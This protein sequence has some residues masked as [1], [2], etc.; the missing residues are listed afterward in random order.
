MAAT[1]EAGRDSERAGP[2]SAYMRGRFPFLGI[3]GPRLARSVA[4]LLRELK[5]A[6]EAD[7]DRL[8]RHLWQRPEREFQYVGTMLVRRYVGRCSPRFLNT[9]E[10]LI[11]TKSWWDTVD[12]L[13]KDGVG[14]LV[15]AHP[16]LAAAMDRWAASENLW[17][18]RSAILHQLRFK[19]ATDPDRLFAYCRRRAADRDFFLRKAIGWALRE[20]SKTDPRAVRVFVEQHAGELSG[21]SKREALRWL[22]RQTA[23]AR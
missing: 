4:P 5:A 13:A 2:M 10:Y 21:L 6:S 20:Y 18:A 8:A 12:A 11:T 9:L 1:L 15:Q 22:E 7:L 14:P 23:P 3:P 16:Q 17:L 19:R